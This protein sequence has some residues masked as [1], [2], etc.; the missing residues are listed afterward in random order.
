M[1][2]CESFFQREMS[3]THSKVKYLWAADLITILSDI[4]FVLFFFFD[5]SILQNS[6]NSTK[7]LYILK[8]VNYNIDIETLKTLNQYNKENEKYA[9]KFYLYATSPPLRV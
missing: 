6:I 5:C 1:M 2:Q 9:L 8:L 3:Q 7:F 4:H